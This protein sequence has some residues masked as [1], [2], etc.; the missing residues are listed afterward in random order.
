MPV[1]KEF[2][3]QMVESENEFSYA[4]NDPPFNSLLKEYE[5]VIVTSLVTSFGLDFIIKDQHGGDVDTI[6]NVRQIGKDGNM[7]YKNK[8]NE[9]D[10]QNRGEYSSKDYHKGGNYQQIKH[11]TRANAENGVIQDAYESKDIAFS[12][13]APSE[14]KAD[15]DH[16]LSAKNVHDDAG[17][18][19]AGTDGKELANDPDNLQFTNAHLNRSM[20]ADEIPDYIE[21]HPE[22][23]EDTKKRMMEAYNKAK[24]KIDAKIAKDYYSSKKFRNDTMKAAGKLGAKMALKEALGFIFAEVWFAVKDEFESLKKNADESKIAAFFRAIGNGIKHGFENAVAK[25]KDI[26]ARC[27][28]GA[29]SGMLSSI[30]TTICNIFFTTAKNIVKVIRQTWASLV[31]AGK[32]LFIN[33][34]NLLMGERMRAA[35]KILATG[36]SVVVGGLVQEAIQHTGIGTIPVIGDIVSAFCGAFTSGIMTVTLLYIM[37]KSSWMQKLVEHIDNMDI[38][39]RETRKIERA[40]RELKVYAAE[41]A[42]ID[43]EQFRKDT[44]MYSRLVSELDQTTNVFEINRILVRQTKAMGLKQPWGSGSFDEFMTNRKGTLTFG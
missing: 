18:V 11:D 22:L 15:L 32:I 41:L 33:P 35:L 23:D 6:H 8:Q 12:K 39:G 13:S 34:D 31:E 24:K 19:L 17:R 37:D 10:Y 44:D 38:I 5:R 1:Q 30:M 43:I 14:S 16:V 4:P 28:N 42:N 27:S 29:L 7:T 26:I 40:V 9:Q 20:G 36:A 25:Y 3:T 21:K 2:V